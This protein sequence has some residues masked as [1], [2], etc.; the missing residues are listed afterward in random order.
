M[1]QLMFG[2]CPEEFMAR[3]KNNAAPEDLLKILRGNCGSL[4]LD[5]AVQPNLDSVVQAFE[6]LLVDVLA[7][8]CRPTAKLLQ[9]AAML[10]FQCSAEEANL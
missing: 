8:T 6:G 2:P 5:L 7:V 9:G 10:A 4:R 1:A 3:I